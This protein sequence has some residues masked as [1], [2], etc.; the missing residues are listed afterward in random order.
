MK[1]RTVHAGRPWK[2]GITKA[3]GP[4]QAPRAPRGPKGRTWTPARAAAQAS[5]EAAVRPRPQRPLARAE[6]FAAGGT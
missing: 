4:W 2:P 3:G 1:T 5:Q 6:A